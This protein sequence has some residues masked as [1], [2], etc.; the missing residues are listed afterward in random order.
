MPRRLH[1][2]PVSIFRRQY[3]SVAA[4]IDARLRAVD[5]ASHATP[6]LFPCAVLILAPTTRM[7]YWYTRDW[8]VPFLVRGGDTLRFGQ[9]F[10]LSPP[11]PPSS[12]LYHRQCI[13]RHPQIGVPG[14]DVLPALEAL[15]G[16]QDPQPEQGA[17]DEP[18]AAAHGGA[19]AGRRAAHGRDG[20]RLPHQPRL[21]Q[22]LAGPS[23]HQL[24]R[25][26]SARV[27]QVRADRGR[28]PAEDE[29]RVSGVQGQVEHLAGEAGKGRGD[30]ARGRG[31][32]G[33]RAWERFEKGGGAST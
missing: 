22:L 27:R 28:K 11:P 24:G 32:R 2:R 25:V 6:L 14:A 21:R 3:L 33:R 4:E 15:G 7:R 26:S 9:R 18:H 29:L 17:R 1:Q 10:P 19:G 5:C 31:G 16:R 23:V 30:E 20:A 13:T 8:A 12:R